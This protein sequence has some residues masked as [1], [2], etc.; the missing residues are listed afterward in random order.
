MNI[1]KEIATVLGWLSGSLAGI[2]ACCYACIYLIKTVPGISAVFTLS[3][4][5]Y[6]PAASGLTRAGSLAAA[7]P[8]DRAFYP[9]RRSHL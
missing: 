1:F 6:M 4:A 3:H 9:F 5:H 2:A 7:H 8:P